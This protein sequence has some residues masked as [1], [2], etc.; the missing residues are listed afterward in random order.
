MAK[1]GALGAAF[2]LCPLNYYPFRA[3]FRNR[4]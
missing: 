1:R 2:L 3:S 4:A